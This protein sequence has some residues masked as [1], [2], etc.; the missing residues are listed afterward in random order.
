M[1]NDNHKSIERDIIMSNKV[2]IT[3]TVIA[4][5]VTAA[6]IGRAVGTNMAGTNIESTSNIPTKQQYLDIVSKVCPESGELTVAECRCAY[7]DM[8]D[9]YGVEETL[10]MDRRVAADENDIDTRIYD[11]LIKCL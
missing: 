11:S 8:I 7:S 2:I 1:N 10:S 5:L 9:K 6:I 3:I 4:L